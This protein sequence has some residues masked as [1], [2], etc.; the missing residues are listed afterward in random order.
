MSE[1][2]K[3]KGFCEAV[4]TWLGETDMEV[5]NADTIP[6]GKHLPC[7]TWQLPLPTEGETV[8][9][10]IICWGHDLTESANKMAA[11]E[12]LLPDTGV[13]ICHM[14]GEEKLYPAGME[15]VS[16]AKRHDGCCGIRMKVW[17][18]GVRSRGQR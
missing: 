7:L 13:M 10:E 8:Q 5:W 16:G 14:N 9:G 17:V 2:N 18:R 3:M 12:E 11:V 6:D 1:I 4:M 15:I